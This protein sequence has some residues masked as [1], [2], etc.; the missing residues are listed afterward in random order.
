M[1][2]PERKH[3]VRRRVGSDCLAWNRYQPFR[4]DQRFAPTCSTQRNRGCALVTAVVLWVGPSSWSAARMLT[5]QRRT[6]YGS[7]DYYE[8]G[9]YRCTA[10][11]DRFIA[12]AAKKLRATF[13][14][15]P[16][17]EGRR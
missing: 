2:R 4:F 12:R 17:H 13:Y 5:K 8:H 11:D 14:R 9:I 1:S 6:L 3:L 15:Q 10:N 16:D 7:Q